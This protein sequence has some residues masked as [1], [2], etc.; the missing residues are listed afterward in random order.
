MNFRKYMGIILNLK[1]FYAQK[2][3]FVFSVHFLFWGKILKMY[4][5]FESAKNN[6]IPNK[7]LN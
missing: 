1:L 3:L 6:P 2:M 4:I 7:I 5:F